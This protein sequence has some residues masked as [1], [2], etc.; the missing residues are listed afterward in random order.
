MSIR[1]R[2]G[3]NYENLG[4][5]LAPYVEA[6]EDK[7]TNLNLKGKLLDHA[8][9]EQPSW[10]SFYDERRMELTTYVKLFDLEI[11]RVRSQLLKNMEQ[12]PRELSDRA[13][14]KYIDSHDEYLKVAEI[15]ITIN[16]LY[17]TYSSLCKAYDHRGF[18]LR[19]LTNAKIAALGDAII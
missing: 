7:D 13:K 11:A 4:E 5:V 12:Y 14:E 2:F 6:L 17:N 8:N 19:N 10:F 16:E 9:R 1:S 15:S 18:A 3:D